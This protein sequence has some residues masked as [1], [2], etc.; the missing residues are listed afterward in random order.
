M[1]HIWEA[2]NWRYATKK[3][4]TTKK[5]SPEQLEELKEAIRLTPSSFGLQPWKFIIVENQEIQD[6]LVEHSWGQNQVSE[7]SHVIV[8]CRNNALDASL[9]ENYIADVIETTWAPAE[10]LQWY[11]DMMLGFINNTPTEVKKTWAEKQIY[12][13][14]WNAMTV[15][16]HMHIDS[17]PMEGFI[18]E[19][20]D[21]VLG[22]AEKWLSSVVVL[23]IGFRSQDDTNA[24]RPK[25]R[26][27]QDEL[28]IEM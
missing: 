19:K 20:Y 11:K 7:A 8:F 17:C 5:V 18:A 24:A 21:E 9:V 2:L 27:D 3:F 6:T 22:L 15:L 10:A 26:Y 23:P 28:F 4:D 16:A 14:L 25:V 1:S 12:I 13:A